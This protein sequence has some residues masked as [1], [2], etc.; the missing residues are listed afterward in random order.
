MITRNV[1]MF[2]LKVCENGHV[3]YAN[4]PQQVQQF[5]NSCGHWCWMD[6]KFC[7]ICGSPV[8]KERS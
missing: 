4:N 6:A 7:S 8:D 1:T 5:L 2:N 3:A